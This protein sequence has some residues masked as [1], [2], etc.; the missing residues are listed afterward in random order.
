MGKRQIVLAGALVGLLG[1]GLA[2]LGNPANMGICVVCFARDVAGALGLHRVATVQYLRPELLGFIF[3]SFLASLGSREWRAR[4][5]SSPA[6]RFFLAMAVAIGA[7]AFLGCPLRMV[8]RLAGGDLTA[9]FGL[10]GFAA[11]VYVGVL[12]LRKGFSLGRS[13]AQMKVNGYLAPVLAA[14]LLILLLV[15]PSFL[16][17]SAKGP[18]SQHVT[19]FIGLLAGAAVGVAAQRTRL[20]MMGGIRDVILLRD[21]HLLSGFGAILAVAFIVNL[22]LGRFHLGLANQPIAHTD[23]LFNFLGMVGAGLGSVLL[24]GCPLRQFILAGEGDQDALSAVLGLVAGAA[25]AHNFGLA[26]S[27]AGVPVPGKVAALLVV[28]FLLVV[29]WGARERAA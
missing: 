26:A 18:G 8:L 5:G 17:F 10:A 22:A 11:G 24:G 14:G 6:L 29:G 3:G 25:V 12:F 7:L 27:P 16:F 13:Q 23:E 20:C 21:F 19:V 9:L 4:G 2:W 1:A 28:L 15:R